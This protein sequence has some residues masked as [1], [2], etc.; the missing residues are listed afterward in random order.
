M[1]GVWCNAAEGK[2]FKVYNPANKELLGSVPDCD[3]FDMN[4]AVEA[5]EN[6]FKVWSSYTAEVSNC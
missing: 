1:N 2:T 5:A 4:K 6:A 3:I